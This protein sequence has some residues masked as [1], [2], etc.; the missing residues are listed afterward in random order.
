MKLI[1]KRQVS[2]HESAKTLAL[3][4]TEIR[5]RHT[6]RNS[7]HR[8]RSVSKTRSKGKSLSSGL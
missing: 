1:G 4:L 3:R 6:G 5:P 7:P 2:V 8:S